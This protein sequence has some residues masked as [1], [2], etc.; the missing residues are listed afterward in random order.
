L[1]GALY[2]TGKS[3]DQLKIVMTDDVFTSVFSFRSAYKS[4][5]F[6]RRE[7]TRELSNALTIGLKHG[8]SLRNSVLVDQGLNAF[9][10]RQFLLYSERTDFNTLPIP[11]RCLS[12][13]LNEACTVTFARGSIPDAVRAT[14]SLPGIF[15]PFELNGHEFVDGAVLENLPNQAV[16]TMQ[17]DVVLAVSLPIKPVVKGELDS[18]LGV[19][20]RSFAVAIEGNE[21]TSRKLANVV[22]EPDVSGFRDTDYLKA[23][24]LAARG[25]EAAER[26][27]SVLLRYTVSETE[28]KTYLAQHA[29]RLPGP[30]GTLLRVRVKAPNESVTRAVE[31]KFV[32]LVNHP[33]NTQAIEAL[34]DEVRSDGRYEADYTTAT[35]TPRRNPNPDHPSRIDRLCS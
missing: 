30:P 21:R 18:I 8:I 19:L 13:D 34:L 20:Q 2:A 5:S 22:I 4:R 14:V 31:R 17:A 3:V 10:D 25:Y 16:Q 28:W 6:R 12:T 29:A 11:F 7:D 26:Q 35:R 27:K 1:V 33:P 9:L 15:Q 24:E 32:P 23:R